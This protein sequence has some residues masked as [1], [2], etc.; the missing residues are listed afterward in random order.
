[1]IISPKKKKCLVEVGEYAGQRYQTTWRMGEF[2]VSAFPEIEY[3]GS[4]TL[5]PLTLIGRWDEWE[6]S[7]PKE[8]RSWDN[9]K[10]P[11][12]SKDFSENYKI[13]YFKIFNGFEV[14]GVRFS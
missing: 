10:Q 4:I 1:M 14:N 3:D 5:D 11:I 9:F 13:L 6:T 2:S 7:I 8:L 12:E